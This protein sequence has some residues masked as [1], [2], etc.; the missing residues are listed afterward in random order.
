MTVEQSFFLRCLSDFCN[1]KKTPRPEVLPDLDALYQLSKEQS[2]QS[3]VYDQCKSW[4]NKEP[5]GKAFRS[6]FL[7]DVFLSVNRAWF[8]REIAER[9]D[10]EG[11]TFSCMK[12]AVFRDYYPIPALRTMGDLD[13]VIHSDDRSKADEILRVDMEMDRMIDNHAVWTY[14]AGHIQ[15]EVHDHMFYEYLANQMDYRSYFDQ[16]WD[17]C[18]QEQVFGV[19]SDHLLVP[20]ENF[21]FLFLMTHTAK[22]IINNGS[23][24]RPFLDMVRMVHT[25]NDRMN[26]DWIGR[27]LENLKLMEFTRVCFALCEAWFQVKMPLKTGVLSEEFYEDATKKVFSDGVFGL[28]N[29][30]NDGAQST[31]EVMRDSGPY[32]ISAVKL[33]IYRLFPPYHDMQLIPWYSF[34]D[35]RPWLLPVAWIYRWVYCVVKKFRHSVR[36]LF[37]PILKRGT[38]EKREQM[39]SGWGL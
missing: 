3:I 35:G 1:R 15:I 39:I 34:V 10:K 23:G 17:H 19:R 31:K 6:S 36:L 13:I 24:F 38:I 18:K 30:E 29:E 5:A 4:I 32:S 20:D 21:H 9:F 22:H 27:E 16:L 8:L 26:W 7:G 28:Q 33:I 25:C 37:E 12:G 2:L 14:S 11:I